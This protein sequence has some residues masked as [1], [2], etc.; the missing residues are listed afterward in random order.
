MLILFMHWCASASS[1]YIP[2]P[3]SFLSLDVINVTSNYS[4]KK[5]IFFFLMDGEGGKFMLIWMRFLGRIFRSHLVSGVFFLFFTPSSDCCYF[6]GG[7]CF[8]VFLLPFVCVCFVDVVVVLH[9]YR[10]SLPFP[11]FLFLFLFYFLYLYVLISF[12]SCFCF[13]FFLYLFSPNSAF[14]SSRHIGSGEGSGYLVYLYIF[15]IFNVVSS[16]SSSF[17]FPSCVFLCLCP[18]LI[19]HCFALSETFN[20]GFSISLF[21]FPS[22]FGCRVCACLQQ[23]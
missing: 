17:F 18:R 5:G 20:E 4:L 14:S 8:F 6:I 1:W 21:F 11:L 3:L 16:F 15:K 10:F 2:P 13:C 9:K 22:P 12:A 23:H 7:V 19:I